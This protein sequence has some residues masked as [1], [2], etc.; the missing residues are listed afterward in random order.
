MELEPVSVRMLGEFSVTM[1]NQE[2]NDSDNRSRKVW[3]LLAYMISCRDRSISQDELINLLWGDEENSSNPV[4]ALK[5]MFHRLRSMLDGL[6]PGA[7]HNLILC[8]GGN[9]SWNSKIDLTLDADEFEK[10][11]K[12]GYACE[13]EQEKLDNYLRALE[14]YDGDFLPKLDTEPWVVPIAT[15]YHGLYV[16]TTCTVADMLKELGRYHDIISV[17]RRAIIIEPYNEDLY[18]RL[19]SALIEVG[20]YKMAAGM[21]QDMSDSLF[22]NFGIMPSQELAALYH[23]AVSETNDREISIETVKQQLR[24]ANEATG[25]FFCD[26]DL[27]KTIYQTQAR[28]IVRSGNAVHIGLITASSDS[29]KPLSKQSMDICMENLRNMICTCLRKGDV[30]ARCSVSQFVVLLPQANYENSCMVCRRII[31][32]FNRQYPHSPA[33]IKFSVQPMEPFN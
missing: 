33:S 1:G 29:G 27:F 8:K 9:Y 3:L 15:Y 28:A 22:Q 4:N 7:G 2:I 18:L 12:T 32:A 30:A 6:R 26:Y 25:A 21:Y 17:C 19:M 5:T 16:K 14:I 10:L 20:D 11:C 31:K 23:K 24:E 13:N